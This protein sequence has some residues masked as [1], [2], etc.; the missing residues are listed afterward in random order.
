MRT[1]DT[2]HAIGRARDEGEE[3]KKKHCSRQAEKFWGRSTHFAPVMVMVSGGGGGVR[4]VVT[5]SLSSETSRKLTAALP[6]VGLS[7]VWC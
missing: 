1:A 6:M 4:I 3:K 7:W 2:V 5:A